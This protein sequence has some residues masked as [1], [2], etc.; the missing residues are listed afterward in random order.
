MTLELERLIILE[1]YG[2]TRTISAGLPNA[3]QLMNLTSM[4]SDAVVGPTFSTTT[5]TSGKIYEITNLPTDATE[6]AAYQTALLADGATT[7]QLASEI[8]VGSTFT[9]T[10]AS[11]IDITYTYTGTNPTLKAGEVYEITIWMPMVI[12]RIQPM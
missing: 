1:V 8:M 9:V 10:S 4:P 2:E 3:G 12:Q 6:L 7:L 5:L 11:D